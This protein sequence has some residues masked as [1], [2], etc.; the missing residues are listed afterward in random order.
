M[1]S[2]MVYYNPLKRRI[3]RSVAEPLIFSMAD[4]ISCVSERAAARKVFDR[5]RR[6]MLP[7]IYNRMPVYPPAS[8]ADRH[9]IEIRS[10]FRTAPRSVS[11]PVALCW[12]RGLASY[13]RTPDAG[14]PAGR[15]LPSIVGDGDWLPAMRA[16]CTGLACANRIIF[17]GQVDNVLPYLQAADFFLSPSLHENLPFPY[18]EACAAG[19]PCPVTD[20]GGNTEIVEDGVNGVVIPPRSAQAIADGIRRM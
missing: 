19:L 13:R 2:D 12:T 17:T 5:Y 16:A 7:C 1:F 11:G 3:C 9:R 18:L 15:L 4:G 14:L 8:P 20:V 6:R 10:A